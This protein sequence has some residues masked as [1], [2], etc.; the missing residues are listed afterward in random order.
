[1]YRG[2]Q[3]KALTGNYFFGDYCQG[4]IRGLQQDTGNWVEKEILPTGFKILGF[5]EDESGELYLAAV[6]PNATSST[7]RVLKIVATP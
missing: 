7:G 2:Q 6:D 4:S 3:H 5:G 1:M